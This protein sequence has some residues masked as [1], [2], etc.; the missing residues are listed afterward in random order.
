MKWLAF[1]FSLL[2]SLAFAQSPLPSP[3]EDWN[4]AL[5]ECHAQMRDMSGRAE[6][7][8]VARGQQARELAKAKDD[9]A[10]AQAKIEQFQSET[11][12]R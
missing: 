9:L 4:E 11:H 6:Q 12:P 8:A 1:A 7:N 10:K 3:P 2:S 5:Q